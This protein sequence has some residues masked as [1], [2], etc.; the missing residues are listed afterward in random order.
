MKKENIRLI[1][2]CGSTHITASV[3]SFSGDKLKIEKLHTVALDYD[4]QD[5]EAWLGAI[6]VGIKE[7]IQIGNYSGKA[8]FIIPGNQVLAKTLMLPSVAKDKQAQVL[9][10]EAQH[11]LPYD[12]DEIVW[13]GEAISNDG[14]ESE[15][16]LGACKSEMVD[17]F[18]E[19]IRDAGLLIE[20]IN[21]S[22]ILSYS[23]LK[24]AQ[25]DIGE[26]ILLINLGARSSTLYFKNADGFF[27]RNINYG[28]NTLTQFISDSL[29]KGFSESDE[30]KTAFC[31]RRR[32]R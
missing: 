19:I 23:A 6:S 15:Y 32:S 21:S 13:D 20:S 8:N 5:D 16:L 31:R 9:A 18:C 27:V 10:F 14:V 3:F 29:G 17:Q 4:F 12:L 1:I 2:N 7:I 30:I 26:D 24:Y 28:G 11:N 22:T 25:P